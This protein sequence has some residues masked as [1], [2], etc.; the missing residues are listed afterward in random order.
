MTKLI[1]E[2]DLLTSKDILSVLNGSF[3]MYCGERNSPQTMVFLRDKKTQEE[4][5]INTRDVLLEV[6]VGDRLPNL[7]REV[8]K[9]ELERGSIYQVI[10]LN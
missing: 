2:S 8:S 1:I 5:C 6:K 7:A 3:E 4:R 9:I 10:K